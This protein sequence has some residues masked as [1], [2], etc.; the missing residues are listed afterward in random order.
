MVSA[1]KPERALAS[2]RDA[3]TQLLSAHK[4]IVGHRYAF[5]GVHADSAAALEQLRGA[6]AMI[7]RAIAAIEAETT[8]IDDVK[9]NC[10]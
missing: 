1:W 9:S 5:S 7:D 4:H 8:R 2:V 10:G 3:H 6:R